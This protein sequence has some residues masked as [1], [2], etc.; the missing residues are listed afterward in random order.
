[1][2]LAC[3]MSFTDVALYY[4]FLSRQKSREGISSVIS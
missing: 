2:R 4:Y 3:Q 1:M